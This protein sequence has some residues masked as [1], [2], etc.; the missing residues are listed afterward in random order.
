MCFLIGGTGTLALL[1]SDGTVVCRGGPATASCD[2]IML[3]AGRDPGRGGGAGGGVSGRLFRSKP[4]MWGLY[5][6]VT[7]LTDC[8]LEVTEGRGGMDGASRVW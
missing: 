2:V 5:C 6:D 4:G 1:D 3:A 8:C 7:E